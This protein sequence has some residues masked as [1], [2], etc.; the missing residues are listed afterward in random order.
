MPR[1]KKNQPLLLNDENYYSPEANHIYWSVSQYKDF[2]RCEAAAMARIRGEYDPPLTRALLVGSF[3]DAYIEGSLERF[4]N[5]HPEVFT[6]K[7]EL[8]AEFRRANE[9]IKRIESS[10]KFMAYLS[11][12]K[13]KILVFEMFGVLWKIKMDSFI[14]NKCIVDLK[15]AAKMEWLPRQRY[16]LQGAVYQAGTDACGYGKLPFYLAVATKEKIP[17]LGIFQIPQ[18]MLDMALQEIGENMP[19]LIEVKSGLIAP[20]RC[21]KCPY[22]RATREIK[23]RDYRELLEG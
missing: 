4:K 17:D 22:C 7:E 5:E 23:V 19:H 14:E 18:S 6:L 15:T 9:V 3:V 21:E 20:K 11:G 10:D 8:R 12:E 2:M 16:E 13:Q 1:R